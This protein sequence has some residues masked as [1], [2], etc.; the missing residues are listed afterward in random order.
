VPGHRYRLY[1]RD[2]DEVGVYDTLA[3]NWKGGDS[4]N[5]RAAGVTAS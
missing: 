2:G 5:Y 4:S 1:T 3:W